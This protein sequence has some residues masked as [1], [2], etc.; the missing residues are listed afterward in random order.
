MDDAANVEHDAV[1]RGYNLGKGFLIGINAVI[2]DDG[3]I[4][5][6]AF[7]A[8][9]AFVKAHFSVSTRSIVVELQA[10]Q[11]LGETMKN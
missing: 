5:V 2:N 9:L 6:S 11:F 8:A 3:Y 4:G 10:R 1:L 7:V